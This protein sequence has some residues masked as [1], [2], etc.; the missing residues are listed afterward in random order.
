MELIK[1]FARGPEGK[2]RL[3]RRTPQASMEIDLRTYADTDPVFKQPWEELSLQS[4][5]SPW[6]HGLKR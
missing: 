5:F 4:P 6:E 3:R 2:V 1:F